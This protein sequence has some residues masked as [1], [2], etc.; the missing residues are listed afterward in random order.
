MGSVFL[1]RVFQPSP[2]QSWARVPSRD[3]PLPSSETGPWGSLGGMQWDEA[4]WP[5]Q[6]NG[7]LTHPNCSSHRLREHQ[8]SLFLGCSQLSR[9]N[10]AIFIPVI[11][12]VSLH[13]LRASATFY[14]SEWHG[15]AVA[16]C[17][18]LENLWLNQH[19]EWKLSSRAALQEPLR[20][21]AAWRSPHIQPGLEKTA[22]AVRCFS[23]TQCCFDLHWS[24][25]VS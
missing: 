13:L 7:A 6:E 17:L 8:L 21:G 23:L 20:C 9:F 5:T 10:S 3:A 24:F 2:F 14:S 25:C 15:A 19:Y 18:R 11:Q 4:S 12:L 16:L 22:E 1:G